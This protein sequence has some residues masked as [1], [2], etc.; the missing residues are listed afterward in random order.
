MSDAFQKYTDACNRMKE[1]E[2]RA[3][4]IVGG[5]ARTIG[6]LLRSPVSQTPSAWKSFYLTGLG[7]D[8]PAV[9]ITQ[10]GPGQPRNPLNVG[11]VQADLIQLANFMVAYAQA[12]QEA[13]QEYQK[14]PPDQ[15]SYVGRPPWTAR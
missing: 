3:D 4:T 7:N 14:I 10:G 6:P 12:E 8:V 2:Q 5:L 1:A 9:I 13:F 15:R 11:D